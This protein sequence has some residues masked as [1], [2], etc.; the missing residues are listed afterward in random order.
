MIVHYENTLS[1]AINKFILHIYS[2]YFCLASFLFNHLIIEI[3]FNWRRR[4]L[5]YKTHGISLYKFLEGYLSTESPYRI[6]RF[7]SLVFYWTHNYPYFILY[8]CK[9]ALFSFRNN[10]VY[11]F[12]TFRHFSMATIN[13][14]RN[15]IRS[16]IY[17]YTL[18]F[19]YIFN[20]LSFTSIRFLKFDTLQIMEAA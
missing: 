5:L 18:L 20:N 4:F 13:G 1:Y 14:I 2:C 15:V 7:N 6:S 19:V 9:R 3:Y 17:F 11:T 16:V 10:I 8:L 12:I